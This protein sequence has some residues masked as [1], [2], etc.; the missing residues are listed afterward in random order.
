M[1]DFNEGREFKL[2]RLSP[3]R[4]VRVDV[5]GRKDHIT[6]KTKN[7]SLVTRTCQYHET[8]DAGQPLYTCILET[9]V[10]KI[11]IPAAGV[12]KSRWAVVKLF[13]GRC[14]LCPAGTL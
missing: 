9:V 14:R 6:L 12:S 2:F 3:T 13:S 8:D 1:H 7:G 10:L 5:E 4:N 11:V